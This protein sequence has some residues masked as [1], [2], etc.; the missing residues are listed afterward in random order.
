M[1]KPINET[2]V[3]LEPSGIRRF[4]NIAND[5]PN[6]LSLGVGEP[7]FNTP[8]KASMAGI[9]SIK[10]G[11]TFYTATA[12]MIELRRA[13]HDYLQVRFQLDYHPETEMIVTIGAS[14]S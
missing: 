10:N 9:N 3:D 11:Q 12:G 1:T 13:I 6:V 5:I 14:E 8:W 4:F 7:D 2:I